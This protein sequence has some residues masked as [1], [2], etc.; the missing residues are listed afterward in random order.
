M[1][2]NM[3]TDLL[4]TVLAGDVAKAAALLKSGADCNTKN[5]E[6]ATVLMLAA[7][8][9]NYEM[10]E[11]LLKAGAEVDATDARGWTALF[12]ALFNYEQNRGFPDV[13]SLLIDAGADIEHQVAYGTRPLM[14][15]AGYGEARVVDVLLLAGVDV[16]AV[17]EG[18]R[19][20]KTMA[21]TKDYVEVVNQL[22]MYVLNQSDG[23]SPS[24]SST[25]ASKPAPGVNVVNF[26]RKTTH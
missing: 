17:N 21:E 23:K 16:A 6:G 18:G 2:N 26:V 11:M 19:N 24:C 15:A 22:H 14:I 13:V 12:K 5:E 4:N 8:A 9:G 7:G 20:A 25:G 1:G 3:S 10:V